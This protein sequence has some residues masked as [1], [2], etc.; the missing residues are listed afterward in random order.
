MPTW[1]GNY[2]NSVVTLSNVGKTSGTEPTPSQGQFDH[3]SF[4]P[5]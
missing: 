2:K 4:P 3:L 1:S 5:S